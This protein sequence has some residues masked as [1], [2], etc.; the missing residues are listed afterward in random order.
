MYA[1]DIILLAP[2]VSASQR[3]LH[4]CENQL[5]WLDMSINVNKSACIRIGPRHRVACYTLVTLDGR[6]I[7]WTNSV[8]YL[9]YI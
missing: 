4:V 5:D 8:R 2:S 1:D 6:E 7:E 3:L 9:G